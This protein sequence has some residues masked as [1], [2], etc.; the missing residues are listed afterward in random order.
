MLE[1]YVTKEQDKAAAL[2]FIKKAPKR[3][4]RPQAIVIDRLRSYCAVLTAIGAAER[5]SGREQSL[6]IPTSERAMTLP[7]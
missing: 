3:H 7:I 5:Q 4:G 1:S 2:K 6:A